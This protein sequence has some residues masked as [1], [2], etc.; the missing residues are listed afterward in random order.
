ML[1]PEHL[2]KYFDALVEQLKNAKRFYS[3]VHLPVQSGSDKV[4]H[5]MKRNCKVEEFETYVKE[6]RRKISEI[7]IETDI[8]VGFPTESDSDFGETVEFVKRICPDVTNMSRFGARPHAPASRLKQHESE[9]INLRSIKL[10]R[11]VR[12]VQHEAND[13]FIGKRLNLIITESNEKSFNGRSKGY[14]QII[15]PK[16]DNFRIGLVMDALI[17]S[18]SANV[19]Y[20]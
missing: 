15:L 11:I 7:T 5:D 19:L 14:K 10:S 3:F 12:S 8:I 4:L 17:K 2:G 13:R 1:N 18:A 6:L 16:N 9:T 20:A